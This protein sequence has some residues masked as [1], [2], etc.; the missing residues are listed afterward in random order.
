MTKINLF[1]Y[2]LPP[3][4]IAQKPIEP[5]DHSRLMVLKRESEEITHDWFYN[6]PNYLKKGDL[7]VVNNTQVIS[8][9]LKGHL[10]TGGKAEVLLL[11][12]LSSDYLVWEALVRPGRKLLPG[13]ILKVNG[14]EIKIVK[15]ADFGGRVIKFS[16]FRWELLEEKGEVPLPPYIKEPLKDPSRY[17]T[18]FAKEKGAVAAPTASLHFTSSLIKSL[19]Q[20]GVE[21]V[22]ITLHAGL[23]TF[24]P[25]RSEE[26]E[27]HK[28]HQEEFFIS[29]E[30]SQKIERAKKKGG[31]VVAVG[32]TVVRTLEGSATENGK[33][34]PGHGFTD[35]YICPGFKF[36]VC[37]A[38]ITNFHLPKSTLLILVSAFAGRELILRAYETAV[39]EKYRFFSFGDAMLLL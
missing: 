13:V 7:L 3:E 10:L 32:T 23:G 15:K 5:R 38:I 21:L 20:K 19:E 30:V 26:I 36:K 28:M 24:R 37:D 18:I 2:Y 14:L 22:E 25:V 4:L 33:I 27:D 9:R 34:N 31:R 1:D 12:P 11:R 39:K 29:E 6:L 8:A 17:Q 35:L 16:E